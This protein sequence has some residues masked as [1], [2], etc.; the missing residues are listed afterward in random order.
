MTCVHRPA[1]VD[2][3]AGLEELSAAALRVGAQR[4]DLCPSG[5]RDLVHR[6]VTHVEELGVHYPVMIICVT[7][8]RVRL[9]KT[10]IVSYIEQSC[11]TLTHIIITDL[12]YL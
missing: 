8:Q 2:R 10:T 12:L 5:S 6:D 9:T 11:A 1:H 7:H 4:F 3:V